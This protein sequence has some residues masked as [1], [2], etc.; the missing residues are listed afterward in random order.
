[1]H[2]QPALSYKPHKFWGNLLSLLWFDCI[3][4]SL[5]YFNLK[6]DRR[7]VNYKEQTSLTTWKEGV[8][9]C[10]KASTLW[11][12]DIIFYQG[13]VT[14]LEMTLLCVCQ[15]VCVHV[16]CQC[17]WVSWSSE[18]GKSKRPELYFPRGR[19]PIIFSESAVWK[20]KKEKNGRDAWRPRQKNKKKRGRRSKSPSR[21]AK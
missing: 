21:M 5:I 2:I 9:K 3:L 18:L 20:W 1:M 7:K 14:C 11:A 8:T 15:C 17:V 16:A 10:W 12:F 19:L 13:C 6:F 4:V